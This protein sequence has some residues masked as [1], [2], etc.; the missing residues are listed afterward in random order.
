MRKGPLKNLLM[1][2]LA[3]WYSWLRLHR[4]IVF[5]IADAALV[6]LSF[7]LA[8]L[9][10]FDGSI[11]PR[12]FVMIGLILPFVLAIKLSVFHV[13]RIYRFSWSHMGFEELLNAA[14]ACCLGSISLAAMLFIFQTS[15]ALYG[16]PRSILVIDF[17]FTFLGIAGIRLSKRS[18]CYLFSLRNVR[19]HG[20][21]AVIVGAGDTGEMLARSLMHEE[22]I[23]YWPVGF[24]DDD[25]GKQ[26]T[27]IHGVP[28][29]GPRNRLSE[30]IKSQGLEAVLIAMPSAPSRVI[31]ETVDIARK[32][33][34]KD[35]KIVPFLSELYTGEFRVSDIREVR[36]EDV[37]SREPVSI[38]LGS[39]EHFLKGKNVLVTGAAGSIG[40]ELCRQVLRFSPAKLLAL[41]FDETGLFN[42]ENELTRLFPKKEV[43]IIV[44]DIRDKG[45]MHSIFQ[46]E[47]PKVVFHA[48][49]YKHV[50]MME[51]YPEE[52]AK[53]N[54]FGSQILIEE[55]QQADV[56]TFVLIS[57]DKA[58]NPV[59]IMGMTKRVAEI[60]SLAVGNGA[61]TR[62]IAVRFGNVLGS[63]G[64]VIPIFMEQIR[65]GGPLTVTHPE[66]ERYFMTIPE[67]VLLVLQAGMMGKGGEVFVLDMGKQVRVLDIA[68]ELIRFYNLEPDKDIPIV[69]TGVRPGEKLRE[70]LLTAEEG[71]DTTNHRQIYIAKMNNG[72][73]KEMLRRR[74]EDLEE[75]IG[76]EADGNK[77]KET[78][79]EIIHGSETPIVEQL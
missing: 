76:N 26:Y 53:T 43:Q 30:L 40:S 6:V 24:I 46:R 65:R 2:F 68:K 58:V 55:A 28:V 9:A 69:F 73:P 61:S 35:I 36:P 49:A 78:L 16:F 20:H 8:F 4:R 66:M 29:L 79:V 18:V 70:E 52:A 54:V 10:R 71:V 31:R 47:R 57:T 11:P 62:C 44:G 17:A 15:A 75:L 39:V 27:A 12:Y 21:R 45:K 48:A 42:L 5:I 63:R 23:T 74:L 38:D 32:G 77:I 64:S 25:P 56:E 59:S 3:T 60:I 37:L 19:P 41:D 14:I 34:A 13:F 7:Y 50:P 33:G 72:L 1:G 51:A 22:K 67:A